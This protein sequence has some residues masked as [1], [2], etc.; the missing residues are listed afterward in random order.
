MSKM[1]KREMNDLQRALL[2][3]LILQPGWAIVREMFDELCA[4]ATAEIVQ[5]PLA[6]DRY[7][8]KLAALHMQ[9]RVTNDVCGSVVRSI[10]TQVGSHVAEQQED[11]AMQEIV[12]KVHTPTRKSI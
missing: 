6:T 11:A 8:E 7:A 12:S 5:L 10:E 1:L 9:A 4:I 2:A 3:N